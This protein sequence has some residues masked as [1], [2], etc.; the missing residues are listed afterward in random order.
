MG[1]K[2]DIWNRNS[3]GRLCSSY[4]EVISIVKKNR[5]FKPHQKLVYDDSSLQHA[6]SLV[7]DSI[8]DGKKIALYS[9]YDVD[10]VMSCVSWIWFFKAISFTNYVYYIPD[11]SE[12]RFI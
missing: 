11:R 3:G 7:A 5:N 9:D 6:T 2:Y 1:L 4:D 8:L 12:S 10:G